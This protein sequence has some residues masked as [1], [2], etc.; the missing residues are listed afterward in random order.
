MDH[1]RV[2][3]EFRKPMG[4]PPISHCLPGEINIINA[5]RPALAGL[6]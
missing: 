4:P 6:L 2:L 3:T 5:P 1:K